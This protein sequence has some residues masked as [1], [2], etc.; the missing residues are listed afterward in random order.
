MAGVLSAKGDFQADREIAQL[1]DL[2][3][4]RLDFQWML[5]GHPGLLSHGWSPEHGFIATRWDTYSEHMILQMLGLGAPNKP[6]PASAWR[7]WKR[8]DISYST[9]HYLNSGPLFTHQFSQAWLDLRHQRDSVPPHTNFF[10]NSI[11]ATRAHHAFNQELAID[12]PGYSDLIWGITASDSAKGYVA[13]GGPPREDIIDGT[14]VPCAAAG[15]LMFTPELS[16][17]ALRAMQARFGQ[18]IYGRYGFADAFNPN[19]GWVNPDVIGIDI[20]ITLLSA[21]NLR[22]GNVWKWFMRNPEITRAYQAAGL[23]SD[24]SR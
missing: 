15:S 13:W 9:Y 12:F 16:V 10:A 17:P 5:N 18:Q 4:Q 20:G 22:S 2:L 1:A 21:E 23:I 24:T 19:T 6:L 14:V 3:Y 7:A 11:T 8:N